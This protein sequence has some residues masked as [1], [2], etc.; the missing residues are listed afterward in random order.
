MKMPR[1]IDPNM[2]E[3]VAGEFLTKRE[4]S[5]DRLNSGC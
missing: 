1:S 2:T 4:R 5:K 3:A